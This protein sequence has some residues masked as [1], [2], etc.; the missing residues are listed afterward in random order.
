MVEYKS[1]L[2]T[3][4]VSFEDRINT[5]VPTLVRGSYIKICASIKWAYHSCNEEGVSIIKKD[6]MKKEVRPWVV[7]WVEKRV[8][9]TNNSSDNL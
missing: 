1:R 6:Q 9:F 7:L 2:Q 4:H 3:H 8:E 5:E